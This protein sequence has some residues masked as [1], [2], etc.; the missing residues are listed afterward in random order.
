MKK[1]F[2]SAIVKMVFLD[3]SDVI[4]TSSIGGGSGFLPSNPGERDTNSIK[5]QKGK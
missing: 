3:E 1:E 5:T 2:H 4:A